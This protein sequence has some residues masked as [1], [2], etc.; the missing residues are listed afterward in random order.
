MPL[1]AYSQR[2]IP[3]LSLERYFSLPLLPPPRCKRPFWRLPLP[4][5]LNGEHELIGLDLLCMSS[6]LFRGVRSAAAQRCYARHGFRRQANVGEAST[7]CVRFASLAEGEVRF[8]CAQHGNLSQR[9]PSHSLPSG[10]QTEDR[11]T[12]WGS[13]PSISHKITN[14]TRHH[15]FLHP[16]DNGTV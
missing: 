1:L 16:D 12:S 14:T 10:V 6:A 11:T 3:R 7:P 15:H 9:P 4:C 2:L 8:A 13:S 5:C